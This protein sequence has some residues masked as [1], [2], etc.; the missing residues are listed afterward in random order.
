MKSLV[1]NPRKAAGFLALFRFVLLERERPD[2]VLTHCT[3]ANLNRLS[4]G[5][6]YMAHPANNTSYDSVQPCFAVRGVA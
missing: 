6:D 4:V 5:G 2:A 1:D 3:G